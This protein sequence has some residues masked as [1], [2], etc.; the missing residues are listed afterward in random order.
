IEEA[1]PS[2]IPGEAPVD[3]AQ[4]ELPPDDGDLHAIE[5]TLDEWS[6]ELS[7]DTVPAG[8]VAFEIRNA[9]TVVH[10]FEVEGN[11]EEWATGDLAPGGD[12]TMSVSLAPGEYRVYCPIEAGGTSHAERGMVATLHVR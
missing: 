6:V 10:Q 8:V 12:V 2:P 5:A 11:G 4:A 1:A 7:H 9:G 3:P